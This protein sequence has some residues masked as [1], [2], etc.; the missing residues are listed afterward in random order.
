M[1]NGEGRDL[2]KE[3]ERPCRQE[4]ASVAWFYEEAEDEGEVKV[5]K[6]AVEQE[7]AG[8]D[9]DGANESESPEGEESEKSESSGDETE[10]ES[11]DDRTQAGSDEPRTSE[12][13]IRANEMRY[14]GSVGRAATWPAKPFR[15]KHSISLI[16]SRPMLLQSLAT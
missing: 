6:R 4:T 1:E 15:C 8:D 13:Q 10:T 2:A 7:A 12:D 14:R 11:S 3:F 16:F 5:Q 9:V